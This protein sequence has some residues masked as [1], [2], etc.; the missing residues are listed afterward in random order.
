MAA[1]SSTGSVKGRRVSGRSRRQVSDA[2]RF[3]DD[4][5]ARAE[6]D[7]PLRGAGKVVG[8]T[9]ARVRTPPLRE[10]TPE[11]SMGYS[12][13]EFAHSVLERP[14]L[15]WQQSLLIRALELTADG[16]RFRFRTVV[17]LVG[18]QNGKSTVAQVLTL[19]ALYVLEVRRVIGTA[20]DLDIAEQLWAGCIEMA[21]GVP[22]LAEM[23]KQVVRVN[24]KKALILSNG[25][26]YKTKAAN[27]KAGRGLSGDLVLLDEL[28]EHTSWDSWG[29][30]TKTTMARSNAQVWCLSNAGDDASVVLMSLRKKGHQGVGDPDGINRDDGL[31]GGGLVDGE[32]AGED[33]LGL[34]EWSAAPGRAVRDVDGWREANPSLGF[35]VAE[36]SLSSAA[37][38]DQEP[39]FRTECL[40]Q[41]VT[42]MVEGPFPAGA[43]EACADPVGVIPDDAALSWA[44][45]VSWD[46]GSAYVAVCGIREDGR[47]QV[48]VATGRAGPDWLEWVPEWFAGFVDEDHPARV[49]VQAKAC[50]AA[51]LISPLGEVRGLEVVAW[52]GGDVGIGCG[53]VYDRVAAADPE[54]ASALPALAHRGQEVLDLAARTGAQHV[55]GDGWYWD[56]RLSP[57]NVS[58]LVAATEALWDQLVN[59]PQPDSIY[60]DGPIDLF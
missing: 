1:R 43:W 25:G 20:Q 55:Y 37:G 30:V 59:G 39:V 9:E 50:P 23:I 10:L 27:R 21:E 33:S 45:D 58:P 13:V 36:S 7:C 35:T 24:G 56:R 12:V 16:R 29:A 44:V 22:V 52:Q 54:A 46:R 42:G 5:I 11:T 32:A 60:E 57:H 28:R 47:P 14:L 53:M 4:F 8:C 48:E 51:A 18:R 40:C 34:F 41:W 49:V 19:W 26:S 17:L 31:G 6:R 2:G 15:P 3:Y 38:T